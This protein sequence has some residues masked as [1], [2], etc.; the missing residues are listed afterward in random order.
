MKLYINRLLSAILVIIIL[1]TILSACKS[2]DDDIEPPEYVLIPSFVSL[3]EITRTVGDIDNIVFCGSII[4]FSV[5]RNEYEGSL[6]YYPVIYSVDF[7]GDSLTNLSELQ[8]FTP[9]EP[10]EEAEGGGVGITAMHIDGDGNLWIAEQE[11]WIG[12]QE[13]RLEGFE[14]Q[15]TLR[16]LDPTGKELLSI[17]IN[18]ITQNSE[19]SINIIITDNDGYLYISNMF[20]MFVLKSN[21]EL[22]H[23]LDRIGLV[24]EMIKLHD[25]SVSLMTSQNQQRV[26]RVI[27]IEEGSLGE[28]IPLPHDAQAVFPG[29]SDYI[30]MFSDGISLYGVD[31]KTGFEILLLDWMESG[32][33]PN[34]VANMTFLP[35]GRI[36]FITEIIDNTEIVVLALTQPIDPGDIKVLTLAAIAPVGPAPA[37][38][39][40]IT[41]FNRTSTTHRIE[42]IDYFPHDYPGRWA[43]LF[44]IALDRLTLDITAGK[45]P[46]IMYLSNLTNL[47]FQQW[48]EK[49]LFIDL[50]PLIDSDATLSRSDL[51]ESVFHAHEINGSLYSIFDSF[52]I[53]TLAGLTSV[54]GD[55]PGWTMSEFN[56]LLESNPQADIPFG[57]WQSKEGFLQFFLTLSKNEFIDW[58]AGTVHFDTGG[59]AGLLVQ[60]N[61]LD[62]ANRVSGWHVAGDW[63]GGDRRENIATGRQLVG[64]ACLEHFFDAL[65][66]RE[67]FQEDFTFIGLPSED[68]V[69]STLVLDQAY[70]REGDWYHT[71]NLAITTAC[72]DKQGAWEFI[73]GILTEDYQ[74]RYRRPEG[75]YL[76]YLMFPTNRAVLETTLS[77]AMARQPP[78]TLQRMD[79]DMVMYAIENVSAMTVISDALWAI[80]IESA[81]DYWNGQITLEDA[82]RIVQ[83]RASIYVAERAG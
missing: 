12:E 49:G 42:F 57:E 38:R 53:Y 41:Q 29:G 36:V 7:D 76:Y 16:K 23:H 6:F 74:L 70:L 30:Y 60:A 83:N 5:I 75:N 33:P 50:Y 8:D 78:Y 67:A 31:I 37:L 69:I 62:V 66:L 59:F 47:P 64:V 72:E 28:S 2:D 65:W 79:A 4:Y 17:D 18:N 63:G 25:G 9:N 81:N 46:D 13:K 45:I 22:L 35:D 10:P 44:P 39:D 56:S 21:G 55:E 3:T 68:R 61:V 34:S 26:L 48:A 71:L 14:L 27:D 32:I 82:V 20:S 43:D 11:E 73:R 80:I 54:V 51:V 15:I 77:W 1:V 40:F 52:A 58:D 19:Q 24:R